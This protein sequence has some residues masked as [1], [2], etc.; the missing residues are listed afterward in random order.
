MGS[1]PHSCRTPTHTAAHPENGRH[2]WHKQDPSSSLSPSWQSS[3]PGPYQAA[4]SP[5]PGPGHE[6]HL[7]WAPQTPL[8][9]PQTNGVLSKPLGPHTRPDLFPGLMSLPAGGQGA[10]RG[11]PGCEEQAV[12]ATA[13]LKAQPP[14][15]G[16]GL[17]QLCPGGATINSPLPG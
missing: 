14:K 13:S 4:S 6:S 12:R 8:S 11:E 10:G 1:P 5:P 2:P 17:S 16:P 3:R 15:S 9:P 7:C